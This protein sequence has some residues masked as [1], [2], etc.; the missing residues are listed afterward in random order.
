MIATRLNKLTE[1]IFPSALNRRCCLWAQP[2]ADLRA[3]L[4]LVLFSQVA[5]LNAAEYQG[6]LKDGKRSG[7]GVL[8]WDNGDRYEGE[9]KNDKRHGKG[10]L[11]WANGEIY[12]GDFKDGR[13]TGQGI[14]YW[15]DGHRYDGGWLND[16]PHGRGLCYSQ[17]GSRRCQFE[18]GAEVEYTGQRRDRLFNGSRPQHLGVKEGRLAPCPESPNCV[19]SQETRMYFRVKPI[20]FV[21]TLAQTMNRF[22]Q[23]LEQEMDRIIV[24][25]FDENYIYAEARTAALHF[26]DDVEIYCVEEEKLCHFRSASRLGYSDLGVNLSRYKEVRGRMKKASAYRKKYGGRRSLR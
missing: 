21:G 23:V 2:M 10:K 1:K 7:W 19:S 4:V 12:E 22:R 14:Y 26:T 9:F 6:D 11:V 13:R 20:A 8:I 24:L 25:V 18:H 15:Q 3:V 16:Q 5:V 17:Q